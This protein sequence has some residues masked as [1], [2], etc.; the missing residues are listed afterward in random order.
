MSAQCGTAAYCGRER[1]PEVVDYPGC[2]VWYELMTTDM[3][4]ATG[5]Y[6]QVVGWGTHALSVPGLPYT[7]FTAGKAPVSGILDLPAEARR[8]GARSRWMG[9]VSVN[10]VDA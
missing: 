3:A 10:D 5:F 4:A 2:F 8:M 7:L 9:Y 6:A 1:R